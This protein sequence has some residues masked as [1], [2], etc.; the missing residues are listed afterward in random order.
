MISIVGIGSGAS[1][2]ARCFAEV[3]NYDIYCLN[4]GVEKNTKSDFMLPSCKTPEECE[5]NIPNLKKFFSKIRD[6]VQVFIIGS[7]LSSN[8]T[9]GILEQIRDKQIEVFY[10]QP[11]TEM[12]TGMGSLNQRATFGVLQEYAR[13][14]LFKSI[15]LI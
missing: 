14:G 9:L 13:S 15:T 2:I 6:R 7:T 10:I 3:D 4:D 12:L 11:D 5:E 8:Y 1:A